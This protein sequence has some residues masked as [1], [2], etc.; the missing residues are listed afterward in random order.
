MNKSGPLDCFNR[1]E[2][3]YW[4]TSAGVQVQVLG[5]LAGVNKKLRDQMRNFTCKPALQIDARWQLDFK[6]RANF[7]KFADFAKSPYA[8]AV[9]QQAKTY[10]H[11]ALY[12][13]EWERNVRFGTDNMRFQ[14]LA[15]E[16]KQTGM[17]NPAMKAG[18]TERWRFIWLALCAGCEFSENFGDFTFSQWLLITHPDLFEFI[19][20]FVENS[21]LH[22]ANVGERHLNIV[23][24]AAFQVDVSNY[25]HEAIFSQLQK[26]LKKDW[27]TIMENL[28]P[29]VE[30]TENDTV[31]P[32]FV[33]GRLWKN[34]IYLSEAAVK[35]RLLAYQP[36][37]EKKT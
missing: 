7:N 36:Q 4:I 23:H 37:L 1:D 24:C 25:C 17:Q 18:A 12:K 9:Q 31:D 32:H 29:T 6:N 33:I 26:D 27:K 19:L 13:S 15:H 28:R 11:T 14:F 34:D 5:R 2:F 8:C 16:G 35:A 20:R 3:M 10:G 22:L 21:V 30:D